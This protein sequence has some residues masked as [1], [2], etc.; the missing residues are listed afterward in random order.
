MT[1]IASAGLEE[2]VFFEEWQK[3][4]FNPVTWDIGYYKDY[5]SDISLYLLDRKDTRRFGIK[6][7]E[8]FPKTIG[9]TQLSQNANNEIIKIQS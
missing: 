6:F 9:Q 2:R 8:A 4:A 3:Q 1:F 7:R 5:V